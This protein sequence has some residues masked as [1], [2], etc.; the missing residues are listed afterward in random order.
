VNHK[1]G[2]LPLEKSLLVPAPPLG[3]LTIP[4]GIAVG[5]HARE[6]GRDDMRALFPGS[7]DPITNGHLDLIARLVSLVD[8]VVVAVAVNPEKT[9]LFPEEERV[10]LLSEACRPWPAVRVERFT[11]LVVDAAR[12][13]AADLI[14]RGIRSV[15]ES[16][17]ELQMARMNRA[18]TGIETL[19]LPASPAWAFVSSSFVREIARFGGEVAPYVPAPVAARLHEKYRKP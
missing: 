19:L 9:P 17:R 2:L 18:Q 5:E 6:C 15:A 11:G 10:E 4:A 7:F 3:I 14:V 13:C 12:Q 16:D 8:E 1:A